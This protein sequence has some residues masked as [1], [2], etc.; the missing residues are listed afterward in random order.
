MAMIANRMVS[1]FGAPRHC[2]VTDNRENEFLCS[3][4]SH[5]VSA[6][7]GQALR[8]KFAIARRKGASSFN[9]QKNSIFAT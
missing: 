8:R 7:I 4:A 2:A 3:S 6:A 1:L 9:R 5:V